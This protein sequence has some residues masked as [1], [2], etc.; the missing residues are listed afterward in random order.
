MVVVLDVS[1]CTAAST[2]G[3]FDEIEFSADLYT[4]PGN[5]SRKT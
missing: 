5:R 2:D 4:G 3:N 1:R